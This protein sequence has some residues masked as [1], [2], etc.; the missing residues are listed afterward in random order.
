MKGWALVMVNG[1]R[2]SPQTI[3]TRCTMYQQYTTE[4]A[5]QNAAKSYK[6]LTNHW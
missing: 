1:D 5:L 6:G 2:C 3:A 4:E